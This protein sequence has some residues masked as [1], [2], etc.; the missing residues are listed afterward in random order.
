MRSVLL[1]THAIQLAADWIEGQLKETVKPAFH[2]DSYRQPFKVKT[3]VAL[4]E[5]NRLAGVA[6]AD[7]AP[8]RMSRS[9]IQI[10]TQRWIR[11]HHESNRGHSASHE[12]NLLIA[13]WV[14]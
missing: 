12:T 1:G 6:E 11:V 5:G 13:E 14:E 3:G 8:L 2:N 7:W 10:N 9:P 4:A